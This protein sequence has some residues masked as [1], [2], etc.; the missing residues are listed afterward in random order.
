[1][2]NRIFFFD[3]VR[4]LA[5]IMVVIM[6][7][8]MPQ[9]NIIG[10]FTWGLTYFSMPCIGL[11][12]T[13]SGALL[14]PVKSSDENGLAFINRRLNKFVFPVLIWSV[15]YLLVQGVFT[16]GDINGIIR[17]LCSIPFKRQEGV[18]WFM[19]TLIGIYL[20]APV[21]SPW[22][23][24]ADKRTIQTYLGIWGI[25]L[26]FPYLKAFV[27]IEKSAYGMYYYTSG[28]VGYFILG[29]YLRRFG[30]NLSL[31][32]SLGGV[33]VMF[34][35]PIIFKLFIDG[36]GLN[37][38]DTFWYLSIDSPILVVLWW[39]IIKHVS[40]HIEH[41]NIIKNACILLSDFSF[42]IYLCH[43]LIMRYGLWHIP[44]IV[45]I[46]NYVMQTCVV[47]VLSLLGSCAFCY[48]VGS[49]PI[50]KYVIGYYRKKT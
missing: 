33:M 44:K 22:L 9:K 42:G 23:A 7:A 31:K 38:G 14:L 32:Y 49:F 4:V 5:C 10:V 35:F 40:K 39:N 20:I 2:K 41:N 18:L 27:D 29:Y 26:L 11:F 1:M 46:S 16:S 17:S 45:E 43:I 15:V 8:P 36:K 30:I 25:S 34:V 47:I 13:V 37:F 12:F 28:F 3:A 24:R 19:Y 6:H 48:V 21:I 50:G